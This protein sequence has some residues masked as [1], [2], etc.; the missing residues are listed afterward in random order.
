MQP[1]VVGGVATRTILL[2]YGKVAPW[3]APEFIKFRMKEYVDK[4]RKSVCAY[5][6]PN[7]VL[8]DFNV[9]A[10]AERSWNVGG[11]PPTRVCPSVGHAVG[12]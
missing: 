2:A 4:K 10:A 6:L 12:L 9:T 11:A 5:V 7:N 1:G 3:S 8:Y